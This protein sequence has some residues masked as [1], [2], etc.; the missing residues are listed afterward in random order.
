M[1]SNSPWF[2]DTEVTFTVSPEPKSPHPAGRPGGQAEHPGGSGLFHVDIPERQKHG[3][4]SS[5]IILM[6]ICSICMYIYIRIKIYIFVIV[7]YII[8]NDNIE[9][10]LTSLCHGSTATRDGSSNGGV[11]F[12]RR[13]KLFGPRLHVL[14]TKLHSDTMGATIVMVMHCHILTH[15][16]TFGTESKPGPMC[17]I[18]PHRPDSCARH[19]PGLVP[20]ECY[21]TSFQAP[22]PRGIAKAINNGEHIQ[23]SWYAV[24]SWW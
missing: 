8:Y 11:P 13:A 4:F 19:L 2:C 6:Y 21:G 16:E 15:I 22:E 20:T 17:S 7:Y 23:T 3:I 12:Q 9:D 1:C 18:E 5:I 10:M 14:S 24:N